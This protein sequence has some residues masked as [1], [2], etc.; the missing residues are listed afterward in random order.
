MKDKKKDN[1][2]KAVITREYEFLK[3]D[4]KYFRPVREGEA[5]KY[6]E[7]TETEFNN[8]VKL[9]K[10]IATKL[11]DS[12]DREAVLTEALSKLEDEYL[13]TIWGALTNPARKP[14]VTTRKHHCVD[15][16]IGKLVVPIV[17]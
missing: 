5:L 12:L 14:K 2:K 13:E 15:M 3:V 10:N 11:K 7:A 9:L 4:G 8:R 16:K 1:K 6:V 17:Y